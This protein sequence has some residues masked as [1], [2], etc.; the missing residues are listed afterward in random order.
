MQQYCIWVPVGNK[1]SSCAK[2]DQS[3]LGGQQVEHDSV[4]R[5]GR[6]SSQL[7]SVLPGVQP[8]LEGSGD[9]HPLKHLQD[10]AW[11]TA[12]SFLYPSARM[13]LTYW[14][15][16]IRGQIVRG[17][18]YPLQEDRMREFDV[19]KLKKSRLKGDFAKVYNYLIDD[20]KKADCSQKCPVLG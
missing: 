5:I 18:R 20:M 16:S 11:S 14:S 10:C 12:S 1:K 2:K 9:S 19:F 8:V 3:V 7:R 15:K 4:A 6:K 17:L 13:T